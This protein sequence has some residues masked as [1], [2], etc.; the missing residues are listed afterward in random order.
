MQKVQLPLSDYRTT[1]KVI[2]LVLFAILFF[3]GVLMSNINPM[4]VL[5]EKVASVNTIEHSEG[6]LSALSIMQN[7]DHFDYY[8]DVRDKY[9]EIMDGKSLY[10]VTNTSD[11]YAA[12]YK[13]ATDYVQY[14]QQGDLH[15][16]EWYAAQ[17]GAGKYDYQE[18]SSKAAYQQQIGLFNE[19][20]VDYELSIIEKIGSLSY[21]ALSF[22][23]GLLTVILIA[24]LLMLTIRVFAE[25]S[26]GML[27]RMVIGSLPIS[28]V[29]A[30]LVPYQLNYKMSVFHAAELLSPQPFAFIALTYLFSLLMLLSVIQKSHSKKPVSA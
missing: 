16:R 12:V 24:A 11:T 4:L 22:S 5:N 10:E 20:R 2:M 19:I 17:I 30:S 7:T 25:G 18:Y 23:L 8:L 28:L 3:R 29:L 9:I 21:V 13:L 1:G 27:G 15:F 6:N 14:Y 26:W